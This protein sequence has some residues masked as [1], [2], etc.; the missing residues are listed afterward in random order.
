MSAH[1]SL[2]TAASRRFAATGNSGGL[3]VT[4]GRTAFRRDLIVGLASSLK[5]NCTS[6]LRRRG[7]GRV[8]RRTI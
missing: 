7:S 5:R 2:S 3:I 8:C 4:T 1:M 6:L